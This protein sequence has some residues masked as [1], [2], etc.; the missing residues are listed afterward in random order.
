MWYPSFLDSQKTPQDASKDVRLSEIEK[1]ECCDEGRKVSPRP[2]ILILT[3]ANEGEREGGHVTVLVQTFG[4]SANTQEH[5]FSCLQFLVHCSSDVCI[6]EEA[7]RRDLYI[8]AANAEERETH[9][10]VWRCFGT[11]G[12]RGDIVYMITFFERS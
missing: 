7:P 3:A 11:A 1:R 6:Q 12:R 4:D 9:D 10:D 2:E 8:A 5:R